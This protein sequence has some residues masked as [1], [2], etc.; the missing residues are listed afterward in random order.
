MVTVFEVTKPTVALWDGAALWTTP[1]TKER[2]L[3][4]IN[5]AEGV[6]HSKRV[7]QYRA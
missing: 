5:T 1:T 4:L 2:L 7:A 3:F 6:A